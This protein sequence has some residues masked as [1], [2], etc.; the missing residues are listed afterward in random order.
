MAVQLA[1]VALVLIAWQNCS[2]KQAVYLS[3]PSEVLGA[4]WQ[5]LTMPTYHRY[6]LVTLG[7]AALGLLLGCSLA[8]TIAGLMAARP[9]FGAVVA[10]FVTLAN[11]TPRVALAPLFLLVFGIGLW[12]K[13]LFVATAIMFFPLYAVYRALISIEPD[14]VANVRILGASNVWLLRDVYV[15]TGISAAS[16]RSARHGDRTVARRDCLPSISSAG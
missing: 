6:V 11:A 9:V 15:P 3:R 12:S 14:T 4:L 2:P 10:P 5:W 8:I 13:V 1:L 7:E 16:A